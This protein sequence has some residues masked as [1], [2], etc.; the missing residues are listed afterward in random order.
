MKT[1]IELWSKGN[2]FVYVVNIGG[3][4][5]YLKNE[6]S[7]NRF[8][9]KLGYEYNINGFFEKTKLSEQEQQLNNK[10]TKFKHTYPK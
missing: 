4:I 2:D 9:M 7:A 1:E 6:S 3:V 5:K 10:Y 8:L